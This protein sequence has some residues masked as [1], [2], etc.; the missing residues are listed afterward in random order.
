MPLKPHPAK[1]ALSCAQLRD[2][3]EYFQS[4][5][6]PHIIPHYTITLAHRVIEFCDRH[7]LGTMP[8]GTSIGHSMLG[9]F[10]RAATG[11]S[12]IRNV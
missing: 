8:W 10:H 1:V 4:K 11:N 6:L 7:R 2:Y 5:S 12:R 3:L 9:P